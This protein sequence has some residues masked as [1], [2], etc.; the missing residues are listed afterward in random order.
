MTSCP[1]VDWATT[2]HS[3]DDGDPD[4]RHWAPMKLMMRKCCLTNC[5]LRYFRDT[6]LVR[7]RYAGAQLQLLLP[8]WP[9]YW[10]LPIRPPIDVSICCVDFG[11]K[12]SPLDE[13]IVILIKQLLRCQT[14]IQSIELKYKFTWVS[15]RLSEAAKPARSELDRYRFIS[16][17]DSSWNTC[18]HSIQIQH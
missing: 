1:S 11:T 4:V 10:P 7:E 2:R 13:T 5:W 15:V 16:K 14:R 6:K 8:C 9:P 12:F 17:V 18:N 3:M